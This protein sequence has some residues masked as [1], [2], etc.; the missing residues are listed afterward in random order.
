M[1]STVPLRVLV[2]VRGGRGGFRRPHEGRAGHGSTS[3]PQQPP[4]NKN[5]DCSGGGSCSNHNNDNNDINSIDKS[6][7]RTGQIKADTEMH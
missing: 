6:Q 7:E 5:Q 1:P 3:E 2:V 4:T